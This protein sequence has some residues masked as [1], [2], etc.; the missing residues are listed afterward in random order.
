MAASKFSNSNLYGIQKTNR[1]NYASSAT[2]VQS[3]PIPASVEY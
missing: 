2:S 3:F 1:L